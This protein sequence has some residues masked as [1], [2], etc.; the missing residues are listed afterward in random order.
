VR[1][2]VLV[3][4]SVAVCTMALAAD[5]PAKGPVVAVNPKT[6]VVLIRLKL[7]DDE[8]KAID[9]INT[10]ADAKKADVKGAKLTELQE[11]VKKDIRAALT[12]EQQTKFDDGM[13]IVVDFDAKV[14]AARKEMSAA[15]KE[16]ATKKDEAKKACDEKIAAATTER[17]KALDEKV[18]KVAN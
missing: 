11:Q 17:D 8:I 12:A 3:V 2:L 14:K 1:K 18:G 10:D 6:D 9:K 5:K 15:V 13:K 4:A 16:D 7:T